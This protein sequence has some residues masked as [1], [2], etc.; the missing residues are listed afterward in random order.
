MCYAISTGADPFG[1]YYRY[2]F[3]ARAVSRLSAPRHL[4]RRL[5]RAD[6]HGRRR[7]PETHMRRRSNAHAEGESATEQCF[8]ID[9]VN[10]LNNA[11]V[12]GKVLPRAARRT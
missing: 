9:D 6:Q 11:D 2:E 3:P 7:D 12:D 5:L 10:F 4:A 8:V 1:P